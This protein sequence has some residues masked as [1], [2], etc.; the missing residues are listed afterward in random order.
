M[1]GITMV[2]YQLDGQPTIREYIL[3]RLASKR[4]KKDRT[5]PNIP[6]MLHTVR[7]LLHIGGFTLLTIAGW[8]FSIILGISIAGLSCFVMSYLFTSKTNNAT[9]DERPTINSPVMR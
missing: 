2:T 9:V 4:A 6:W 7:V 3:L 8:K 1:R 5:I